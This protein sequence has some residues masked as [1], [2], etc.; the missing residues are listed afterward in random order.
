M[1]LNA[2]N[3]P[4]GIAPPSVDV[5]IRKSLMSDRSMP[6]EL[7]KNA[8]CPLGLENKIDGLFF[9]HIQLILRYFILMYVF[10]EKVLLVPDMA[11]ASKEF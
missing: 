2:I 4:S 9:W 8:I 1:Q 6:P 5:T 11:W 10:T 7:S 3:V